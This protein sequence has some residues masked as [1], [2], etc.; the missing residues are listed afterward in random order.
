MIETEKKELQKFL[1]LAL[2][3]VDADKELK[4]S[5]FRDTLAGLC[6]EASEIEVEE[7]DDENDSWDDHCK[8]E[9]RQERYI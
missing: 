5:D 7:E 1:S 8:F 3:I 2:E 6:D 9:S 4:V